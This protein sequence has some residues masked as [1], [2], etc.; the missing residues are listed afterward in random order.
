MSDL[1]IPV[2]FGDGQ[3]YEVVCSVCGC[4]E[5]MVLLARPTYRIVQGVLFDE[6]KADERRTV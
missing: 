2:S 5:F 4:R 6:S 3:T 1:D